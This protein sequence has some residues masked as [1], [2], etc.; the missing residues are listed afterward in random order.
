M[1]DSE[2]QPR[3]AESLP[4]PGEDAPPK[5]T[6]GRNL[7][8]GSIAMTLIALGILLGW[9]AWGRAERRDRNEEVV[10]AEP[11]DLLKGSKHE[12]GFEPVAL[13]DSLTQ[14]ARDTTYQTVI[15]APFDGVIMEIL[16]KPGD[17]VPPGAVL[18]RLSVE[19]L[20]LQL[21]VLEAES[22]V[23]RRQADAA[24][25]GG[26]RAAAELALVNM[27]RVQAK[28]NLLRHRREQAAM[29]SP[30]KEEGIVLSDERMSRVGAPVKAG[31][32]LFEIAPVR[33]PGARGTG[34]LLPRDVIIPRR[35]PD[36][37]EEDIEEIIEKSLVDT[38]IDKPASVD[39]DVIRPLPGYYDNLNPGAPDWVTSG[40]HLK[41]KGHVPLAAKG[42]GGYIASLQKN[43]LEVVFVCDAT[44][45]MGGIILEV[46]THIRQ[47]MKVITTLVPNARVGFVTYRDKKKYDMD[48]YEYTVRYQKLVPGNDEGI[49]RL[50]RFARETEAYGGGDIPEAVYEG[51]QTAIDKSGFRA[52]SRK[53]IIVFGDAP[54]R[55]ENN[56][57]R[58]IYTLCK[59]WHAKTGGVISCIDTNT[60]TPRM[61]AEFKQMAVDGGGESVRLRN[62]QEITRQLF[63]FTFGTKWTPQL[64]KVSK[65]FLNGTGPP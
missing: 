49:K 31:D 43:G 25:R 24:R 62:S 9:M 23:C 12:S 11:S 65:K 32:V 60:N 3:D 61:M 38:D 45:S 13:D 46:K 19:E 35:K 37:T 26:E 52:G 8:L 16:V 42:W 15:A 20:D 57:L 22:A 2:T 47:L 59:T 5:S 54:P 53:V 58:K 18:A 36:G 50:Q 41:D 7:L 56:G 21:A 4:L 28:I 48:D 44:G 6:T 29:R 14:V 40:G 39:A 10:Q 30:L 34:P 33:A 51:V 64:D 17:R 55:P 1:T 63:Y 27:A